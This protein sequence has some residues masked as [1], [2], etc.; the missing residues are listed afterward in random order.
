MHRLTKHPLYSVW[1]GMKRRCRDKR[2]KSY[3]TYGGRGI[4]VCEDWKKSF[5]SFYNWANNSGY[6][7]P[8]TIDRIDTNG[9]YEPSNCRWATRS[10]QNDN[11]TSSVKIEYDGR[12]MC[13]AAWAKELKIKPDT[14]TNR[15]KRG[16]DFHSALFGK[17]SRLQK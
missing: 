1:A 5:L 9:N 14:I 4:L 16:W 12:I 6:H 3:K 15:I 17:I 10:E 11:K 2:H 7:K 8:L 13:A